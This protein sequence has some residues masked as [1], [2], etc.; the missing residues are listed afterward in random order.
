MA[1]NVSKKAAKAD[2]IQS[3]EIAIPKAQSLPTSS[4]LNKSSA[5]GTC[6]FRACAQRRMWAAVARQPRVPFA[7]CT[8]SNIATAQ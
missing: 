3:A 2:Q 1:K 7:I 4:W 5:G 6:T 8:C